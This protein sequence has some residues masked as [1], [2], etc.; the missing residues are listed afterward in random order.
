[1]RQLV[2]WGYQLITSTACN[3]IR[4]K[5]VG[6]APARVRRSSRQTRCWPS[7]LEQVNRS[8]SSMGLKRNTKVDV[9]KNG[10]IALQRH[11]K[12][13]AWIP[14]IT[15]RDANWKV[16][17]FRSISCRKS[18]ENLRSRLREDGRLSTLHLGF[19]STFWY[20]PKR[21]LPATPPKQQLALL[22]VA[23]VTVTPPV[24]D[25]FHP[26]PLP[27][28]AT[29]RPHNLKN[30]LTTTPGLAHLPCLSSCIFSLLS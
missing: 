23:I 10:P 2:Y 22:I 24:T 12:V 28:I 4:R 8:G 11:E 29:S 6:D 5:H 18:V 3:G 16:A 14:L 9:G 15:E 1:M 7:H 27:N 17:Q 20:L 26:S 30:T 19:G 25:S 21:H 13:T